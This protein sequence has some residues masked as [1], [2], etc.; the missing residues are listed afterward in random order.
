MW[1]GFYIMMILLSYVILIST[2]KKQSKVQNDNDALQI[3]TEILEND[4][5]K[6]Y[7]VIS[8]VRMEEMQ[9]TTVIVETNSLNIVLEIDNITGKVL[10]K[11]K[12]FV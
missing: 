10:N 1:V 4:E 5:V 2:Y 11:E 3:T 8:I 9:T 12:L 6:H 7:E